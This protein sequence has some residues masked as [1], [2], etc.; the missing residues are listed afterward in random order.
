LKFHTAGKEY[1]ER[2]FMAGNQQGKTLSGAA[3]F[4]IHLTGRY[5]AWWNGRRFTTPIRAWASGVTGEATRDNAQRMLLGLE[6]GTGMIPKDA[7]HKVR[8][9]R[10]LVDAVDTIYVQH[11]SGGMSSLVFKSYERGREKWQGESLH[12]VWFDEEPPV[13]IYGEGLARITARKGIVFLTFTPLMG[14]SEVVARFILE[15]DNPDRHVTQMGLEEAEHIPAEE[16][17]RIIQ[18][19][20]PH[21]REARVNGVPVL[22]S[23]KVFPIPEDEIAEE[24]PPLAYHWARVCGLD[25]G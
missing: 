2:L 21:E 3:E 18:G 16:R 11:K 25:F 8:N 12:L 19:Y 24:A 14:M 10:G 4:A 6:H 15:P 22:G 13:D 23:G 7:I 17:E 9:S 20:Q 1:R 5:P